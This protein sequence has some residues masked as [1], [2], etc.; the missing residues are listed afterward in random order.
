MRFATMRQEMPEF[1]ESET[2]EN[3]GERCNI[4]RSDP[5]MVIRP[6]FSPIVGRFA[7]YTWVDDDGFAEP[8]YCYETG[9]EPM[10]IVDVF[11]DDV[12]ADLDEV[13]EFVGSYDRKGVSIDSADAKEPEPQAEDCER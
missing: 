2:I 10:D 13:A 7:C 11:Y 1:T 9:E 12:W 4:Q 3:H 8:S 5:L 6:S